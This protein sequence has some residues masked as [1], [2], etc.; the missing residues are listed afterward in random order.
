M[1][2]RK[3]TLVL[4]TFVCL[5]IIYFY[6]DTNVIKADDFTSNH[7]EAILEK[8]DESSKIVTPIAEVQENNIVINESMSILDCLPDFFI[9]TQEY[10]KKVNEYFYSLAE[11][12]YQEELIYHALYASPK[13]GKNRLDLLFE[14]HEKVPSSPIVLMNSISLC[15]GSL[16]ERCTTNFINDALASDSKNG[17][18]WLSAALYYASNGDDSGVINSIVEL[19]KTAIFNERFGEAILL[20]TQ[21][22]EG[23]TT[24]N[25]NINTVNAVGKIASSFPKYSHIVNWCKEGLSEA[26]K[27]D[28][29]LTLGEQMEAR[30]QTMLT[31]AIGIELQKIVY[32][33]HSNTDSVQLMERKRAEIT[34][35]S[36]SKQYQLADIMLM[37]DERLL[38]S[39]LNNLDVVGEV[40]S[41]RLSVEES[42]VLYE[43]ND[44]YLCTLMYEVASS[45]L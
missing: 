20:Y 18:V 6:D 31:K 21:A 28:S 23:S 35:E 4:L 29:C 22:L 5:V 12:N 24:N 37:L 16:D 36:Q 9:D 34:S 3:K 13:E 41:H 10:N 2:G 27:A 26:Q 1:L 17:A 30:G 45:L 19:E 40:E 11:S 44:N 32:N 15:A 25:F 33:S 38:R 7:Y 14:F 8:K 43:E 42:H 39:W